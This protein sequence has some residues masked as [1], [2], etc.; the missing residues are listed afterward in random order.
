MNISTIY[1]GDVRSMLGMLDDDSVDLVVTS[2]PYAERRKKA[3]GGIPADKYVE[4]FLPISAE[5]QRVLK[6]TRDRFVLNIKE[7]VSDGERQIYVYE[8]VLA[9]RKQEKVALRGRDDLA[10]DEP[11]SD[12]EQK[13]AQG[14]LRALL[15]LRE[16]EKVQ[17]LPR[18]SANEI[19]QQVGGGQQSAGRTTGAHPPP[20]ALG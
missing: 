18:R 8:L 5:L 9:L 14:R 15:P 17:V 19:N 20:T 11:V 4:W 2:P 12:R 7:S 16:D 13:Q 3:Y 10:Q 6:P 1:V